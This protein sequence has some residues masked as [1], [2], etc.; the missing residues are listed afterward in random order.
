MRDFAAACEKPRA[1]PDLPEPGRTQPRKRHGAKAEGRPQPRRRDGAKADRPP[2]QRG[3]REAQFQEAGLAPS[4]SRPRAR[5]PRGTESGQDFRNQSPPGPRCASSQGRQTPGPTRCHP[6]SG[7]QEG[8][9]S[10]GDPHAREPPACKGRAVAAR[11]CRSLTTRQPAQ[12]QGRGNRCFSLTLR[13]RS[14][15]IRTPASA[16]RSHTEG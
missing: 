3:G 16:T 11:P 2:R 8:G 4:W 5:R 7:S 6:W 13:R 10:A 15:E 1:N 12:R 14:L 9:S